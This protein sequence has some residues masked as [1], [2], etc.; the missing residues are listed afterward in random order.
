MR[1]LTLVIGLCMGLAAAGNFL[2]NGNFEDDLSVGWQSYLS[3]TIYDTVMRGTDYEPDPDYE[4]YL[5][6]SYGGYAEL[7]QTIDIT[8]VDSFAFSMKTKLYA[9]DNNADT[10]CWAAAAV[11]VSYMN[12]TGNVL[13]TTRICRSTAP[14]PWSN[15]S[16]NHLIPAVDTLWHTYSFNLRTELANLPGV[17]PGQVKKV[18]VALFDTCAHTC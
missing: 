8:T 13:G 1:R 11:V 15:T 17:V 5:F 9:Y 16:T 6:K 10:L 4:A 7:W 3:S 14:C 12:S 2:T 18:Q